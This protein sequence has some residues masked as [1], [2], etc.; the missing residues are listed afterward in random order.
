VQQQGN[1]RIV[2]QLPG[3]QDTA[4]AK[5][6]LGR[7]ATLE[8]RMVEAQMSNP[9]NRDYDPEKVQ[10]AVNGTVRQDASTKDF[11]VD[12]AHA[13]E[14]LSKHLTL[15]PCDLVL[16]GTPA[17]VGPLVDGDRVECSVSGIGTLTTRILRPKE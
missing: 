15:R 7:T 14:W 11:V 10:A 2:V 9:S 13:I 12:V 4:R 17:G 1:D 6:I 16:M 8:F 5:D 3:I